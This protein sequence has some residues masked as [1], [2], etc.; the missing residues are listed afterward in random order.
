[1]GHNSDHPIITVV[2]DS[3]P[4]TANTEITVETCVWPAAHQET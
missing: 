1:V 4:I 2:V 3:G